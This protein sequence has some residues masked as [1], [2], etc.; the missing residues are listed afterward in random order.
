MSNMSY[1]RFQNTLEDLRDCEE[2]LYEP[3]SKDE[4][5]A[6]INLLRLAHRIAADFDNDG[7]FNK[8]AAEALEVTQ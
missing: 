7:S 2:N 3:C 4:H 6:R 5:R 1:C 8:E